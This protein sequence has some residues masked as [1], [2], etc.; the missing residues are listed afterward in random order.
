MLLKQKTQAQGTDKLLEEVRRI[1]D[2]IAQ[3][4]GGI[5]TAELRRRRDALLADAALGDDRAEALTD[6][7]AQIAK[8]QASARALQ[9]LKERYRAAAQKWGDAVAAELDHRRRELREAA[10]QHRAEAQELVRQ[11]AALA[12]RAQAEEGEVIAMRH[13]IEAHR[14][15]AL[16]QAEKELT[17]LAKG[18]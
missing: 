11:A 2:A 5:G 3:E 4:P 6:V 16:K 17:K 1:A 10:T 13:R 18:A 15:E 12:G 9:G 8:R 7:D 14:R